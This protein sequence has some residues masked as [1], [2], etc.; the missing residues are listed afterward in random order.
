MWKVEIGDR[1]YYAA[2]YSKT[3]ETRHEAEQFMASTKDAMLYEL[4]TDSYAEGSARDGEILVRWAA[5]DYA[6]I[7]LWEA[8][9]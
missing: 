5:A 8:L 1:A 9:D 4:G 7:K 6:T 3:F 2:P